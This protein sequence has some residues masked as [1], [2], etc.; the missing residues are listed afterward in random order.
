MPFPLMIKIHTE[1]VL[2]G[3]GFRKSFINSMI[4]NAYYA[5][6]KRWHEEYRPLH[7]TERGKRRYKMAPRQGEGKRMRGYYK[8][9]QAYYRARFIAMGRKGKYVPKRW[10]RSYTGRK[11]A[12][13]HHT[14]PLVWSGESESLTE[15]L[16]I[17][18]TK[19]GVKVVLNAPRLNFTRITQ[20]DSGVVINM[21]EETTKVLPSEFS[22]LLRVGERSIQDS[23]KFATGKNRK[24][25]V[26]SGG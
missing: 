25:Q 3:F 6:G 1:G 2:D 12:E 16:D 22:D 26:F 18:A 8:D 5:M 20:D 23:I 21:I 9:E 7:F 14:K 19:N 15:R 17:R 11:D 10:K 4:R 24:T 13:K